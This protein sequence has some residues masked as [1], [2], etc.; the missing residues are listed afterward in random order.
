[1]LNQFPLQAPNR[2]QTIALN[3]WAPSRGSPPLL[4]LGGA[5]TAR[6]RPRT[7]PMNPASGQYQCPVCK[8][9]FPK[10][11]SLKFH[12]DS[13]H[14]V[15]NPDLVTVPTYSCNACGQH[16]RNAKMKQEHDCPVQPRPKRAPR[17]PPPRQACSKCHVMVTRANLQRHEA[18][19]RGPGDANRTC[20]K[21]H[22]MFSSSVS[23][24]HHEARCTA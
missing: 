10:A 7:L 8:I 5:R 1:M 18:L 6:V 21:C 23:R 19:C 3:R 16:W 4:N 12:Y 15:A 2:E 22:R 13:H 9:E 14:A 24:V 11:N 20:E 17:P